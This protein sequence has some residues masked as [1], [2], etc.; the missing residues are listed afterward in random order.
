MKS[1]PREDLLNDS[2]NDSQ[3]EKQLNV[4]EFRVHAMAEIQG[5]WLSRVWLVA[6]TLVHSQ[7]LS[8]LLSWSINH[9]S[10]STIPFITMNE[11]IKGWKVLKEDDIMY[12]DFPVILY[13][14]QYTSQ[15]VSHF[16]S[17]LANL[18]INQSLI[19]L[20]LPV[21]NLNRAQFQTRSS[22][23]CFG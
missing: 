4:S 16:S 17:Q 9:T 13:F 5:L 3:H 6:R 22:A 23:A 7:G 12:L 11:S 14:S 20:P 15:P 2:L 21:V 1:S 10:Y 8:L 19:P 18:L